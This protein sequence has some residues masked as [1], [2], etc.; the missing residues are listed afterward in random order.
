MALFLGM[1]LGSTYLKAGVFDGAGQMRGLGRCHVAAE[2]GAGVQRECELAVFWEAFRAAL[3]DALAQAG[4][5]PPDVHAISCASQANTFMLAHADDGQPLSP[6]IL[7]TDTR[8][9]VPPPVQALWERLD[10]PVMT[11]LGVTVKP[12]FAVAK[13]AWW[14]QIRPREWAAAQIRTLP[15]YVAETLTGRAIVDA[16]TAAMLGILKQDGACWWPEALETLQLDPSRLPRPCRAGT[17]IGV[18]TPGG[19]AVSGLAAGTRVVTGGLDHQ[20]AA[21]GAELAEGRPDLCLSLGTVL[22]AVACDTACHLATDVCCLPGRSPQ[23]TFHLAFDRRGGGLLENYR[24]HFAPNISAADLDGLASDVPADAGGV[25]LVWPPDPSSPGGLAFRNW[26]PQ[27]GHGYAVRAILNASAAALADVV[28]RVLPGRRPQLVAA[29]GGGAVS[30][31]WR[32]ILAERLG[33]PVLPACCT[34]AAARGGALLAA[35]AVAGD[36]AGNRSLNLGLA[37]LDKSI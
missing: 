23:E 1:D 16:G 35:A 11:G 26:S 36:D 34:E 5:T 21:M 25:E 22:A 37:P 31:R 7:W 33:C 15:D 3:H 6:L 13:W 27:Q 4:A 29:V 18:V 10:F 8:G 32:G 28:A 9:G 2:S 30:E 12:E 24:R 14:Q 17:P 20:L 19:S